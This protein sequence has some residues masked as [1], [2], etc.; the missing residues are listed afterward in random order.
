MYVTAR[1][2]MLPG[3]KMCEAADKWRICIAAFIT[4]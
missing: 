3:K 4:L 2:Y 1:L